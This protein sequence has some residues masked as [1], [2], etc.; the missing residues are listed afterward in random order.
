MPKMLQKVLIVF[1]LLSVSMF[2]VAQS[3]QE[4]IQS[5]MKL[6]YRTEA[7]LARDAN[8]TPVEALTFIGLKD[9]MKVIEFFPARRAWYTKIL[10]PVL[11]DKGELHLIDSK[12]TFE[13]WGNMLDNPVFKN[14][15]KI[16]VEA[17]YNRSEGRYNLGEIDISF[18]DADLFLNIWEY[19]NLNMEDKARLNKT[20]FDA[21]KSGGR[22]VIVDHTRRHNQSEEQWAVRREDPVSTILNVQATGFVLEKS[23]DMFYKPDDSLDKEVG[24]ESVRGKSDRFFLVFKKP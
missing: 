4:K 1:T 9:D 17:S 13:S 3:V 5:A 6:D 22:Y 2:S 24:H 16:P 10:A 18:N 12:A 23:S 8:R 19:H 7:G 21:L 20:A 14:T 15:H 11:A